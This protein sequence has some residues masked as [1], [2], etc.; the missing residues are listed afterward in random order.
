M[1]A[2]TPISIPLPAPYP[3]LTRVLG[4]LKDPGYDEIDG[5]R[6]RRGKDVIFQ[7]GF[8]EAISTCEADV[9]WSG[10]VAS[11]GKLQSI[12]ELVVTPFGF[13]RI[14]DLKIGSIISGRDGGQ[15]RVIG[16]YPQGIQDIYEVEFIDGATCLVGL[17]HLW[18]IRIMRKQSKKAKLRGLSTDEDYRVWTTEMIIEFLNKNKDTDRNISIPLCDPVQ[19]TIGGKKS[20]TIPPY[21]LGCLLGDGCIVSDSTIT[22]TN[23]DIEVIDNIRSYGYEVRPSNCERNKSGLLS[24]II[25]HPTLISDLK[26][27]NLHG[28][29]SNEKFI[30]RQYKLATIDDRISLMQGLMDTDGYGE[31]DLCSCGISSASIEMAKDIQEIVWSLGGYC[32]LNTR[33]AGYKNANGN[34]VECFDRNVL[35]IQT[36]DNKHLFRLPRKQAVMKDRR[37]TKTRRIV[38]IKKVGREKAVCIAVT[39]PDSLYLT[40]KGCIVTHN[41]FSLLMEAMRGLGKPNYS[42]VIV[43]KELV[44]VGT[45]GG[46]LSDA[47]LIYKDM[48]GCE[49]SASDMA[50]KWD[51]WNSSIQF[52]HLNLQGEGQAKE[53][54]EKMKNKQASYI[55]IDELTNFTYDIWRYWFSRNR[56]NSGMKPRFLATMNANGWHWTSRVL[57]MAG[58]I[59]DDGYLKPNMTGVLRYMVVQGDKPEDI[60]WADSKEQ[61]LEKLPELEHRL[62]QEMKAQGLTTDHLIKSFTFLPG[63]LMDNRILT[64]NT[65]GGNVANLFNVGEAERMKL[66]YG[67]WG[68]LAEG[69]SQVTSQEVENMFFGP[70]QNAVSE[71]QTTYL[72]VDIGDGGDPTM[73]YVW[74]GLSVIARETTYTDDAMEKVAWVR[75]LMQQYDVMPERVAVDT[76][77]LGNYFDSVLLGVVGIVSNRVPIKEIDENNNPILLEQ[78]VYLTDQLS[79][80]LAAYIR[81]GKIRYEFS[82]DEQV[83][84]GRQGK[85]K[86]GICDLLK[87]ET[88]ELLRRIQNDR[89]RKYSFSSKQEFKRHHRFSPDDHDLL[90]YRMVFELSAKLKKEAD[91]EYSIH[92]YYRALYT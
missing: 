43:K 37:Y 54:Q 69:D 25:K 31:K 40:G 85:N 72:T 56:D 67:Y 48:P 83:V 3:K 90:K 44:E 35:Y 81:M 91:Q 14:G 61:M 22:F 88:N 36:Q 82:P 86:M 45:A 12:N 53:A 33:P 64:Y 76:A 39:N 17:D 77:G 59:G 8:Q 66:L 58:Y 32:S 30:P 84:Y 49:Y 68:E 29:R 38:S 52:T 24:W 47:K 4:N 42:A 13:R 21:V 80:K 23:P 20:I 74:R 87:I 34:Y 51:C 26:E 11:P 70:T 55:A 71:D 46:I 10:G 27:L 89:T 5:F 65:Q 7:A 92:D 41:T 1:Q 19:F 16:I 15:Q 2:S 63:N 50:F 73:A 28:C 60:V 75:S 18:N 78:Y 57:K 62:T 6:L 9:I 79:G